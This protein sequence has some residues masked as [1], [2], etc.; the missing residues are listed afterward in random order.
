ME[1]NNSK[2]EVLVTEENSKDL[3]KKALKEYSDLDLDINDVDRQIWLIKEAN[4][5]VFEKI[6]K[7]QDI[8][9]KYLQKQSEISESMKV[10]MRE[11]NMSDFDYNNFVAKYTAPSV[12][13]K[14]DTA[15]F[16]K[17]YAPD[18]AMYKKY[19]GTTSVSDSVKITKK[20]DGK[21]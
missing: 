8:K 5:E 10:I 7:L 6:E 3:A 12:R 4:A 14:F 2:N 20:A 13:K 21:I 9:S 16:Y 15:Q 11:G 19:V 1:D 18:T 17:D